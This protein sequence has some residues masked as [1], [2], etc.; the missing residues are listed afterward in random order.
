MHFKA[1]FSPPFGEVLTKTVRVMKL[2]AIILFAACLQVSARGY[3]QLVTLRAQHAP[4]E[5]VLAEIQKQTGFNFVYAKMELQGAKPVDL[6]LHEAD[7]AQTLAACFKDQ[8]LAYT[9]VDQYVVV[10]K[11]PLVARIPRAV[12]DSS[13]PLITVTGKVTDEHG[14]ALAGA[15]I[16]VKNGKAGTLTNEKGI[17]VL[18]K[19]APDAVLEISFTGYKL[20]EVHVAGEK[21]MLAIQLPLANSVL[22][23]PQVIAYGTTTDRLST[24]DV[25]VVKG[26]DIA[27]QPVDNVLSAI[28]DRVPG[29]YVTPSSGLPGASY[30]VQIRG[31]NSLLNGTDPLYVVDGVPY[32]SEL[33]TNTNPGGGGSPLDFINPLDIESVSVLKDADATSIYGSRAAN[34]AILITTKKG[35]SGKTQVQVNV[36]EGV[37]KAPQRLQWL[38]TTQYLQLRHEAFNNDSITPTIANAPDLLYWDTTR[39]TNWQKAMIGGAAHYEDAQ[40]NFS[41]GNAGTQY[42]LGGNFHK[43]NTVF[44]VTGSNQNSGVHLSVTNVSQDQK[45]KITATVNYLVNSRDLPRSDLTPFINTSPDAP[46]IRNADGTLNWANETWPRGNPIASTYTFYNGQTNNLVSNVLLSYQVLP[47]LTVKTSLGYSNMQVSETSATPISSQDP[48]FSPLGSASFVDNTI[49]G[50]IAEPQ[51]TYSLKLGRNKIEALAGATFEENITKSQNLF[52]SN[53]ASDALLTDPQAAPQLQ[54]GF[55]YN[56]YK[57]NALFFRINYNYQDKYLLNLSARRDGSSR[58]GPSNQWHDFVSSGIG[59]I[60]SK[61]HIIQDNLPFLSYG[62][63]RGSYGTTGSDQIGDYQ[64]Y[65]LFQP[66]YYTYD[67]LN[68]LTPI[69]LSNPYLAWEETKKLEGAIELGFLKDRILIKANYYHN[70]SSNELLP[71]NVPLL[72]GFSSVLVNLPATVQNTGWEFTLNTTNIKTKDCWWTTSFNL[73]VPQNKLISYPNL[74]SSAFSNYFFVGKSI[75]TRQLYHM[76]GVDQQSGL[77]QFQDYHGNTTFSPSY[78]TDR[79]SYVSLFPK[80]YGGI[81]NS[82]GIKNW[83]LD[84][85]LQFRNVLGINPILQQGDP[86]QLFENYPTD[87]M[88]RWQHPGDKTNIQKLTAGYAHAPFLAYTYAQQSD[89]N[90]S[91]AS[92]IR[93]NNVSISYHLKDAWVKKMHLQNCR[94]YLHGENLAI[95]SKYKSVDPEI[96]SYTSLPILRVFTG[97]VLLSL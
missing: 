53:F 44:P 69:G 66:S 27:M 60:F 46:P 31:I 65:N 55:A 22:D 95:F 73:T 92:F 78:N 23:A 90:Y 9:I 40:V 52:G 77:Y 84:F 61:E 29:L 8:P 19:V 82:F 71:L 74:S 16:S 4:L 81:Q 59:W 89:G 6:D 25:T 26:A 21:N 24:G 13:A 54:S 33:L 70:R 35:S 58:F 94:I 51:A 79:I 32:A 48:A 67:S 85:S 87:I 50:W 62:K 88:H 72:T 2:T 68:T 43:E 11:R 5:Q 18:K 39:Y 37:A 80:F 1:L 28:A 91:S 41:G 17:F 36:Q 45:F 12:S 96:Q 93:L 56:D 7:L 64:F 30:A 38:N 57:Y 20:T 47:G 14:Q 63:I 76:K 75:G 49:H 86:M 10:K 97:G 3:G 15:S 42:V 34:G 83:Q